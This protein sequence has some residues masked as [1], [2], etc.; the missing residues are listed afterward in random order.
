M[1]KFSNV[2]N[3]LFPSPSWPFYTGLTHMHG[4]SHFCGVCMN[5]VNG[6]VSEQ[7]QIR[8]KLL[9]YCEWKKYVMINQSM[10]NGP[11]GHIELAL[12]NKFA[13]WLCL[14]GQTSTTVWEEKKYNPRL[15]RNVEEFVQLMNNLNLPYP[16]QI[17]KSYVILKIKCQNIPNG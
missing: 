17:G 12:D 5:I 3:W 4:Y 16:K 9:E 14:T 15:T 2:S 13:Y 10:L 11:V 1:N 7:W 6:M 8:R